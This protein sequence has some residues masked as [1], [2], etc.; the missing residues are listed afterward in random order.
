MIL[1][2]AAAAGE[3]QVLSASER[4]R[5]DH[6]VGNVIITSSAEAQAVTVEVIPIRWAEHC[7]VEITEQGQTA[8]VRTWSERRRSRCRADIRVVAPS[9]ADADVEVGFGDLYVHGLASLVAEVGVGDLRVSQIG[10]ESDIELGNGDVEMMLLESADIE[11]GVG[12]IR[13]H[14][15][16][17]VRVDASVG[18]GKVRVQLP[19]GTRV[20]PRASIGLGELQVTLPVGPDAATQLDVVVGVGDIIILAIPESSQP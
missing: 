10:G 17:G 14:A 12:D 6:M 9:A 5:I 7:M 15:V 8:V 16:P 18:V 20:N 4:I 19:G 1:F 11:L 3:P 13:L 2:S